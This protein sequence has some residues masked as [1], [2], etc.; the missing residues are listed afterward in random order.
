MLSQNKSSKSSSH[1]YQFKPVYPRKILCIFCNMGFKLRYLFCSRVQ[2]EWGSETINKNKISQK[3]SSKLSSHHCQINPYPCSR[4]QGILISRSKFILTKFARFF[5]KIWPQNRKNTQLWQ[6][7]CINHTT[8]TSTYA[9]VW[10][11]QFDN[12]GNTIEVSFP[13]KPTHSNYG[14]FAW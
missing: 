8:I 11:T 7:E 3:K 14:G 10:A 5:F 6:V 12:S 4:F 13:I 9:R 2:C 1:H